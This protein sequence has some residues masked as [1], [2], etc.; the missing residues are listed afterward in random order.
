MNPIDAS[1]VQIDY[2]LN[3]SIEAF[4][5]YRHTTPSERVKLLSTITQLI[6]QS[7]TQLVAAAARE[8]HLPETRLNNELNRTI[9]QL[10]TYGAACQ[11]GYCLEASLEHDPL[12]QPAKP[13]IRKL[14]IPLGP[15]VVFGSSN[16]PFAYSTA[17][18][19]TASALAAGCPVVVKAHPAHPETST[20][21]A[22]CITDAVALC[23]LPA[24]VFQHVYGASHE[25]GKWLVQHPSTAA[26][27]FTGSFTGGK[28]L[29]DW[30]A[31]RTNPIPVFAEMGSLNPVFLLPEKLNS[32]YTTIASQLVSSFT[33]G[34]GQFCTKPGL[35]IGIKSLSWDNFL[36]ELSRHTSPI[37]PAP[38]L[39]N[40][41]AS[42]YK[43]NTEL[44][45]QQPGVSVLA[46]S[47][48][49]AKQGEGDPM[50]VQVTA[51]DWLSNS[52]LQ[53]EN[54][55]PFTMAI[56]C[57]DATELLAV[58]KH[59]E[60][61]LTGTIFAEEQELAGYMTL[62]SI[63]EIRCGRLIFN[64]VPTGVEVCKSMQHGGP[65]PATS[66]ARFGAVGEDAIRRFLRPIAYQNWPDALLPLPLQAKN[67]LA[68]PRFINGV[69]QP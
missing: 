63:L 49:P 55:G 22:K 27:G 39:H 43:K 24:G 8:S 56:Q 25:V 29:V 42:A 38:L 54:F 30:A 6:E 16:F 31:A 26:V 7:R 14:L 69:L 66:D 12:A 64:G 9:F 1:Q 61:Q 32:S 34:V 36:F 3:L 65:F 35:L 46:Q 58:A 23:G 15:V 68:V 19:D 47:N 13:D 52:L 2:T 21:M 44:V 33:L 10:E 59:L 45:L 37:S 50:V 40:G 62:I 20:L 51:A 67:P 5:T 11:K 41:I 53:V 18:G 48:T 57:N 17:G 60:G 28:Q 4:S